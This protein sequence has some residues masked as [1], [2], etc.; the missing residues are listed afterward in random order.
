M[1]ALI[2]HY[3]DCA[4]PQRQNSPRK[5]K[6]NKTNLPFEAN[7]LPDWPGLEKEPSPNGGASTGGPQPPERSARN[8]ETAI[9]LYLREIGQVKPLT[10]REE[11]V[12]VTRVRKGDRKAREQLIKGSLRRVAEI[13]GEF[14]NIGLSQL[15]LISEGNLGLLKAVERF[16]PAKGTTFSAF[17][18]WW[19]K[20]SIKRAL[21]G[22]FQ[23]PSN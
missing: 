2:K 14:E 19:I 10:P 16:D 20:Q 15:D 9:N 18:T 1:L 5:R 11:M 23:K 6:A 22:S 17:S 13:S 21:S 4:I 3:E 8:G 12:L 7:L